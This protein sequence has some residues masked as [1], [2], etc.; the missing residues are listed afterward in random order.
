[1]S[2]DA[3]AEDHLKKGWPWGMVDCGLALADWLV[4]N[5]LDDP[6]AD[7]RHCY[8]DEA[9][10]FDLVEARGGLLSIVEGI[11]MR[12]ELTPLSEPEYGAVA[13]IGS[14]TAMRR[15]WGAI[16]D[17][18][19]WRVRMNGGYPL[20]RAWPLKIWGLPDAP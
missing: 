13:V 3:F 19:G 6:A 1:M 7:L 14:P 20:V 17:G 2:F 4:W 16:F 15:Q 11:A 9:G 8:V 18:H 10:C 5:G 12:V